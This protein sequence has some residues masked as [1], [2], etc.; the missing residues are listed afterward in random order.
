MKMK[1]RQTEQLLQ[2]RFLNI[3]NVS[4][5]NAERSMM[6][7]V[8]IIKLMQTKHPTDVEVLFLY[9]KFIGDCKSQS[10]NIPVKK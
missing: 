6:A 3:W 10:N 7:D 5:A 2:E 9:P 4:K 8:N 1:H